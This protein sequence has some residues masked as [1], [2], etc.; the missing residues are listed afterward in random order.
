M[1]TEA[2][3]YTALSDEK[4]EF[5][6]LHLLPAQN[7]TEPLACRLEID[8]GHNRP[9]FETLSYTWGGEAPREPLIVDETHVL[10]I[11]PNLAAF[12][13][14]RRESDTEVVLWVDA[15]CINQNDIAEK[16]QQVPAMTAFYL[17]SRKLTIW[18][19]LAAD[20]SDRAVEELQNLSR[21]T[22]YERMP[23]ISPETC[24]AIGRLLSRPWWTRVWIVQELC[25]GAFAGKLLSATLR[26]GSSSISWEGLV[27]AC[28]RIRVHEL[29]LRQTIPGVGNVLHLES[30]RWSSERM[31]VEGFDE[32]DFL[33]LVSQYR[34]FDATDPRDKIY[35][36]RGMLKSRTGLG[37]KLLP[38]EYGISM[39]ELF[40]RFAVISA[41]RKPGLGML[42]HCIWSPDSQYRSSPSWVPDWSRKRGEILLPNRTTFIK[43]EVPWWAVPEHKVGKI[44]YPI[45]HEQA[46]RMA[47]AA[48]EDSNDVAV[49]ESQANLVSS[50]PADARKTIQDLIDGGDLV[51]MRLPGFENTEPKDVSS[52]N[53]RL[54]KILKSNERITQRSFLRDWLD[55]QNG[56]RPAYSAGLQAGVSNTPDFTPDL[57]GM[58]LDGIIWDKI[59]S[60]SHPFPE[61]LDSDWEASTHF[62]AQ[63]AECKRLAMIRHEN[64]NPYGSGDAKTR[65]FWDTLFAGQAIGLDT[66]PQDWLP[67]LPPTWTKARPPLTSIK[68]G[69]AELTEILELMKTE[70]EDHLKE[71]K[72]NTNWEALEF[73]E[74]FNPDQW[75]EEERLSKA[76]RFQELSNQWDSQPY[77]L[78]HRPFK[79]P[80]VVPDPYWECRIRD[81][82]KARVV[83]A[84]SRCKK[85]INGII[86]PNPEATERMR[87]RAFKAFGEKPSVIPQGT[88]DFPIERYVLGRRFFVT[89]QGYLG[90]GP[91]DAQE[92]DFVAILLTAEVPFILRECGEDKF[93]V[94]GETYVS[95][96]MNGEAVDQSING[97][98]DA[99]RIK[100]V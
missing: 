14:Q 66:N 9:S 10:N 40:L 34:H 98:R 37:T 41:V 58:L 29:S 54:E 56:K 20:D 1:P 12:L 53:G 88:A 65:A 27:L 83:S 99:K 31:Y 77:D 25:W 87:A 73:E 92:G 45:T 89:E 59:E 24:A 57:K 84:A 30:K 5:R 7:P 16:N 15:V 75:E 51:L 11:T 62:M 49:S 39:D 55:E 90:I 21:S 76:E 71:T 72:D 69:Q 97:E 91:K 36:L 64:L 18:L 48:L 96:I 2:Y 17:A 86:G 67:C 100:L 82:K 8:S 60:L 52:I 19:G 46:M 44:I 4:L 35:A 78:Y 85:W 68:Q 50:L 47:Q 70:E 79:L 80:A 13:R 23:A 26:C 43:E 42:R 74:T 81:D 22:V 3:R 33:H 28:G 32:G 61:D 63:V 38:V 93:K 94:V 95:G 6:L